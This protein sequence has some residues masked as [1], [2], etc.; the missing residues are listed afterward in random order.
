MKIE[1]SKK[2]QKSDLVILPCFEDGKSFVLATDIKFQ[3]SKLLRTI[4]D[5]K[6]SLS[7]VALRYPLQCAD[8]VE[9]RAVFLGLGAKSALTL[10]DIRTAYATA[11]R[12]V[13]Q[14]G[15]DSVNIYIPHVTLFSPSE[16][17]RAVA[18]GV[19]LSNYSFQ[20]LKSKEKITL[21]KHVQIMADKA[22]LPIA[23][24]ALT[25]A[26]AVHDT[27]DLVNDNADTVTPHYLEQ[28][29]ADIAKSDQRFVLK[30]LHKKDIERE[31]MGLLLA[32]NRGS[33]KD[34]KKDPRLICLS[35]NGNPTSQ[36][37]VALIGKGVT[38]DTGGLCLKPANSMLDMRMDMGGAA[39]VLGAIKAAA[40]L[41]LKQNI[42][43][44]VPTTENAIGSD[45]YKVGDVVT[46]YTGRT[47][48]VDNTDAEGRLIL[49]DAAGYCVDKF[50]PSLIID[51]ATLTGAIIIALGNNIAGLFSD[52]PALV[53]ILKRSS[54]YTGD[55]IW[56]MPAFDPYLK[57]L[58]SEVADTKNTGSR[59]AGSIT[60]GLFI[61]SFIK[62]SV[63][64]AHFDIA[65]VAFLPKAFGC[66]PKNATGAVVRVLVDALENMTPAFFKALARESK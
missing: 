45:S 33:S 44:I 2:R 19:T 41:S 24:K 21:I 29:A 4:L 50:K 13:L 56:P 51:V 38:Y 12:S 16:I 63:P 57:L 25:I 31:K 55:L 42:D 48:E 49:A 58:K 15:I 39:T 47:V 11:I 20:K 66:N 1:L 43:A 17:V 53:E 34:P 46:S 18:E 64:W 28:T 54:D 62:K 5:F 32:V 22:F 8:F 35:Y 36:D 60:A 9:K 27:R 59:A 52:S 65:G 40:K 7:E 37:R 23:K 61:R 10:D 30:V 26:R 3:D 14:H 6:A